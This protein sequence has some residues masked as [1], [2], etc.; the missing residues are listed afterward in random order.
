[1]DQF[2]STF[3]NKI[4]TKGRVSIPASFRTVLAKDGLEG[5]YCYP[6]LDAP[7]LDAG[8]QRLLNKI[9][10]LVED[11][12]PYS[13]ERDQLA[14]ALFGTSEILS[15]DQ[16]GRTILP[17]RLREHAGITNQITFVGLGEKFQ[18]WEPKR[19]ETYQAEARQKVRDLRKLLGAGRRDR[20]GPEG[21]RE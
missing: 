15:I 16:D 1:M 2:V 8:G 18:L 13:D 3:T 9:N 20:G 6:S 21:A 10:A 4:D 5:I 14:T 11:L 7:A 12:A 17:E 19:F